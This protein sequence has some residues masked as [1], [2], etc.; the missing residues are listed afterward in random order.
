MIKIVTIATISMLVV[1]A[2]NS[3]A[4]DPLYKWTDAKG[5]VHFTQTPPL[6]D[7]P[8]TVLNVQIQSVIPSPKTQI[9]EDKKK[10]DTLST[11]TKAFHDARDRNCQLAKE[12]MKTLSER[13][14]IRVN[15]A[16]G[17]SRL[18]TEQ[19][20]AEKM[21]LSQEQI[22]SFCTPIKE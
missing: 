13:A 3:F 16:D 6:G 2:T 8:Y 22:T 4:N 19:E 21:K 15:T 14:R 20:K 12:N 1:L 17:E 11:E 9:I 7:I 18:L 10:D 5:E